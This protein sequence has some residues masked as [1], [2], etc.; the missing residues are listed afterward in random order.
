MVIVALVA[1]VVLLGLGWLAVMRWL[2]DDGVP[3]RATLEEDGSS[4]KWSAEREREQVT[5]P[6]PD[7]GLNLAKDRH[8]GQTWGPGL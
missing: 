1:F 8:V 2:D 4:R 3:V 6:S 7:G 5:R